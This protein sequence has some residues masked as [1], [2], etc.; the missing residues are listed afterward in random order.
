MMGKGT[1]PKAVVDPTLKVLGISGAPRVRVADASI[2]P[3]VTSG[4]TQCPCYLI[5][6]KAATMIMATP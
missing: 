5:G 6:E 2:M 3:Q 1:D 4:N